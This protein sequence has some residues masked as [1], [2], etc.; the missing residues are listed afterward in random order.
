MHITEPRTCDT[1]YVSRFTFHVLRPRNDCRNAFETLR[2]YNI[3][4]LGLE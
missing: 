4:E 1:V 2:V 3:D